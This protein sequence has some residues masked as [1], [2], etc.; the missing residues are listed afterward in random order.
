MFGTKQRSSDHVEEGGEEQITIPVSDLEGCLRGWR[1]VHCWR[2]NVL[3]ESQ[4]F[5]SR[6]V[7]STVIVEK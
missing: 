1:F 7:D 2:V 6:L 4:P 5:L 3:F